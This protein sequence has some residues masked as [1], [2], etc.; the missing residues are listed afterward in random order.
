MVDLCFVKKIETVIICRPIFNEK[1]VGLIV[2][3]KLLITIVV[4][5]FNNL[6]LKCTGARGYP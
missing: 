4:W 6:G 1:E 2:I 3:L 5:D